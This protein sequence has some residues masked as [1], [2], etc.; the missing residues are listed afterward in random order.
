MTPSQEFAA[1][2]GIDWADEKHDLCLWPA[3]GGGPHHSTVA[4]KPAAI[5]AWAAELRQR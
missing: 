4:Q 2:I 3:A 1:F 5:A